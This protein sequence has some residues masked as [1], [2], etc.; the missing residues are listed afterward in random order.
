V[1]KHPNSTKYA[2]PPK[3]SRT[4]ATTT[5]STPNLSKTKPPTRLLSYHHRATYLFALLFL[6]QTIL[7]LV[8]F[9]SWSTSPTAPLGSCY[10]TSN[11]LSAPGASHPAAD[12][13]YIAITAVWLLAVLFFAIFGG[14]KHRRSVLLI[15]LLQFPVHLYAVI[16]LRTGN[17]TAL[18]KEGGDEEGENVWDFGQTT[19]VLLLGVTVHECVSKG[20]EIWRF[21]REARGRGKV[22]GERRVDE[23]GIV[24][25]RRDVEAAAVVGEREG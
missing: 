7:L 17:Q 14:A 11:L 9:K 23:G 16:A 19:A 18:E 15:A 20:R 1:T 4:K 3:L 13:I 10:I 2:R 6:A 21:E 24:S 22:E 25:E 12:R 5:T 8:S